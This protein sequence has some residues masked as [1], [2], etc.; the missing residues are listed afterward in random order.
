MNIS[1]NFYVKKIFYACYVKNV[2]LPIDVLNNERNRLGI[3]NVGNNSKLR[4]NNVRTK[5]KLIQKA[6]HNFYDAKVLSF[7]TLTYQQNETDIRKAKKDIRLF[8]ILLKRWWNDPIR[9]KYMGELKHFYVYEYQKRG[10][11]HFHVVFNR[12]IPYSMIFQWWPYAQKSG[13]KLIVVKKG[14]NEFV[15]KYLSKYV[16]KVQENIKSLNQK[17]VGVQAYAFS[18]NCKNPIVVRGVKTLLLQDL[19]KA[20]EKA[21]EFY[22]FKTKKNEQGVTY[23]I[24]GSY[25]YNV[26]DD[27]FKDFQQYVSLESL[28]FRYWL[29][30]EFN[31]NEILDFLYKVFD[32]SKIEKVFL[33]KRILH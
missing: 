10:A 22:L 6:L 33:Q 31:R 29:K 8:F 5:S 26:V 19:V 28:R 14:T 30:N 1:Y 7:L 16:T 21:K 12:K 9:A 25:D 15:V 32:K 2:V 13:I 11:V 23:L 4:H 18:R 20:C 24:G 27:Y 17:D 3:K